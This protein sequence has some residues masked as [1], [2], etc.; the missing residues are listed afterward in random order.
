VTADDHYYAGWRA[1]DAGYI[2]SLR[3]QSDAVLACAAR[4]AEHWDRANA[5]TRERAVA[6]RLRGIGYRLKKDYPAAITAFRET[7]DLLSSLDAESVD[8]AIGLNALAMAESESAEFAAA[9]GHYLEALRVAR[10]IGNAE[11]IGGITGNRAELSL[12]QEDW[13]TA[14]RLALEALPLVEAIHRQEL[15][16]GNNYRIA[17]ALVRQGKETEALPYAQRAVEVFTGMGHLDLA[18][19]EAILAECDG[20]APL[21][22][23]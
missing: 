11:L 1:S 4:A 8:V 9:E 12:C 21:G 7:V 16:A 20:R 13:P 14:E 15:I 19:A 23:L 17:K 22:R 18:A 3:Q 6:V 5:G 2:H 10:S